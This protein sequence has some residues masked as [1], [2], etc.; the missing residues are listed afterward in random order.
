M[1]TTIYFGEDDTY[2]IKL[3]DKKAER[4]RKSRSA[5][6]MEILEQYFEKGKN[7]GEILIDM[8][9]LEPTQ[10][11]RIQKEAAK[12]H[13]LPEDEIKRIVGQ[14]NFQHAQIIYARCQTEEK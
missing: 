11:K 3:I 10:F 4:G 6:I 7:I 2:L 1:Q 9:V 13:I 5:V 8:G 14:K 12:K